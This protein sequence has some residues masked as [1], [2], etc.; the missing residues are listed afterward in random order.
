ME[1]WLDKFV[2]RLLDDQTLAKAPSVGA[3]VAAA[4]GGDV[5]ETEPFSWL[6]TIEDELLAKLEIAEEHD[7]AD[8]T[9]YI[10][11]YVE[12]RFQDM[13]LPDLT[14][15]LAGW[16]QAPILP[17]GSLR[18]VSKEWEGLSGRLIVSISIAVELG[19][20]LTEAPVRDL[21]G[22]VTRYPE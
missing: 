12:L 18:P 7:A 10:D 9:Q 17:S 5:R 14:N 20:E 11:L 2:S 21:S 13:T 4:A 8:G 22:K 6:V 16:R 19:A 15:E 3:A 1:T